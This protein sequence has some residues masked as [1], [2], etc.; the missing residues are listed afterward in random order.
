MRGL[1][2]DIW[3][4]A[5]QKGTTLNRQMYGKMKKTVEAHNTAIKSSVTEGFQLKVDCI[6]AE[7]NVPTHFQNQKSLE[8]RIKIQESEV[9][10][11]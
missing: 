11:F 3:N 9:Y 2:N 4:Q 7:K 6:N 10:A 8:P 1:N 5:S